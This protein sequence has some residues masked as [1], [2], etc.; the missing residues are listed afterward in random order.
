MA[1]TKTAPG[2]RPTQEQQQ[3]AARVHSIDLKTRNMAAFRLLVVISN[4]R[5]GTSI[6]LLSSHLIPD[7]CAPNASLVGL[8]IK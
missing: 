6:F 8:A 1:L 3:R 7:E 4:K 2:F 5:S